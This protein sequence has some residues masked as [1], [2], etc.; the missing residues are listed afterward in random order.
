VVKS[1]STRSGAGRASRSRIVV[2]TPL[3]AAHAGQAQ[4]AQEASDALAPDVNAER[5]QLGVNPAL[6]VWAA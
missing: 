1:R 6:A 4:R 2:R 3:A 5:R